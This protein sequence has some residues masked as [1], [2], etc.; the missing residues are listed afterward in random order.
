MDVAHAGWH[1][2]EVRGRPR[3]SASD[4]SSA[5]F[6]AALLALA[7]LPCPPTLNGWKL[8]DAS[9][10]VVPLAAGDTGDLAVLR[11][12]HE[13]ADIIGD[14]CHGIRLNRSRPKPYKRSTEAVYAP[15]KP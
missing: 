14:E 11:M 8:P 13:A 2:L 1:R 10:V 3:R 4:G 7:Y 15:V 9:L 5:C 12:L 6:A